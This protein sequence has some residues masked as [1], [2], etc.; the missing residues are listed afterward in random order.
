M[1]SGSSCDGVTR[2]LSTLRRTVCTTYSIY[3]SSWESYAYEYVQSSSAKTAVW[4]GRISERVG[5]QVRLL[6]IDVNTPAVLT[7]PYREQSNTNTIESWIHSR[8]GVE[9]AQT[10][11]P[12]HT[13]KTNGPP[14]YTAVD[15]SVAVLESEACRQREDE[16]AVRGCQENHAFSC[17]CSRTYHV[18]WMR[19]KS[20][21]EGR[22][23]GSICRSIFRW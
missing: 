1:Y 8:W 3:T 9:L 4:F 11:C 13:A 20:S 6:D 18:R 19:W 2:V 17:S 15:G 7:F 12:S 14:W 23:R 16:R 10:A 5:R 22:T 21:V